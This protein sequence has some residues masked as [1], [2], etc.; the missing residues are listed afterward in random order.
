MICQYSTK[1]EDSAWKFSSIWFYL[2]ICKAEGGIWSFFSSDFHSIYLATL[3]LCL[4]ITEKDISVWDPHS[5]ILN[6]VLGILKQS[7]TLLGLTQSGSSH[8]VGHPFFP[9][10]THKVLFSTDLHR[11]WE[12]L[13]L[14][15]RKMWKDSLTHYFNKLNYLLIPDNSTY[16]ILEIS[17]M[18]HI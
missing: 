8:P 2:R 16:K 15:L 9:R 12:A 17:K 7:N 6:Q 5:S 13:I 3:A 11:P 18:F 1:D 14:K 4:L 10:H